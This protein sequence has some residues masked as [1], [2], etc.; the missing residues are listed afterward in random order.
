MENMGESSNIGLKING[1]TLEDYNEKLIHLAEKFFGHKFPIRKDISEMF[2][3]NGLWIDDKHNIRVIG[4]VN[5][6]FVEIRKVG[7]NGFHYFYSPAEFRNRF[8]ERNVKFSKKIKEW[9]NK[10]YEKYIDKS[11]KPEKPK[12]LWKREKPKKILSFDAIFCFKKRC[13]VIVSHICVKCPN[14]LGKISIYS[15][16]EKKYKTYYK[17]L[18][19]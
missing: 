11:F 6:L 8:W 3:L 13:Y 1:K 16:K 2:S 4:N 10:L 17:C 14:Y 12:P 7:E 5:N 18:G 15:L 9:L 19:E